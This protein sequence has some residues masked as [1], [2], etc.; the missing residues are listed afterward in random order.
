ML[1]EIFVDMS[2]GF[3]LETKIELF[4]EPRPDFFGPDVLLLLPDHFL[5]LLLIELAVRVL[6]VFEAH[7]FEVV[8]GQV[9]T[10]GRLVLALAEENHLAA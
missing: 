7:A 10:D 4:V 1:F 8:L 5:H 9:P 6:V 3:G 2:S